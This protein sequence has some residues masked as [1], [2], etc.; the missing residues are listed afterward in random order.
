MTRLKV[1]F[2]LQNFSPCKII[3]ELIALATQ[4]AEYV[5]KALLKPLGNISTVMFQV[6]Q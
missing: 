3:L 4:K 5:P 1:S 6:F 2:M